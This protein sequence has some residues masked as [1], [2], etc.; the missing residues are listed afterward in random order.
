MSTFI[1]VKQGQPA[2]SQGANGEIQLRVI[3]GRYFLFAKVN[4]IW[5]SIELV[6]GGLALA[7][8]AG[9]IGGGAVAS[10]T[11]TIDNLTVKNL[12]VDE[13]FI[14]ATGTSRP[15]FNVI[16]HVVDD[17]QAHEDYIRNIG[18]DKMSGSLEITGHDGA[19]YNQDFLLRLFDSQTNYNAVYVKNPQGGANMQVGVN[20]TSVMTGTL[21][22]G[23]SG[24]D[25]IVHHNG[26]VQIGQV[27]VEGDS[28]N[29]D[30]NAGSLTCS[31]I[32]A[33]DIDTGHGA[34][35]VYPLNNLYITTAGFNES[36]YLTWAN[37][38]DTAGNV[39]VQ[40]P[41]DMNLK[42]VNDSI[43]D[44]KLAYNTGQH[45]TTTSNVIH[46]NLYLNDAHSSS[47]PPLHVNTAGYTKILLEDKANNE[48]LVKINTGN[49]GDLNFETPNFKKVTVED[50]T[51]FGSANFASGFTGAGWQVERDPL[52]NEY[53]ATFDELTVRG[54]LSVYELLIQQI[55]ATNG[56][57]II[58]SG[59]RVKEATR[60][61]PEN[62][63]GLNYT[64]TVED[65]SEP[66]SN[67]Y[68]MANAGP[69][70]AWDDGRFFIFGGGGGVDSW[71][72][73]VIN[74]IAHNIDNDGNNLWNEIYSTMVEGDMFQIYENANNYGWF[75]CYTAPTIHGTL[76][77]NSQLNARQVDGAFLGTGPNY[78]GGATHTFKFGGKAATVGHHVREGDLLLAQKWT[79]IGEQD[80]PFQPIIQ[81]KIIVSHIA[82]SDAN[83]APNQFRANVFSTQEQANTM[84]QNLPLDF[85]RVGNET[86]INRQGGIYLTSEDDGAPFIDIYDQVTSWNDWRDIAKTKARLGKLSGITYDSYDIGNTYGLFSSDVFLTGNITAKGGYIGN[87]DSGWRIDAYGIRNANSNAESRITIGDGYHASANTGFYVGGDGNFSL[88]DKL[89]WN[90]ASNT[91]AVV[92]EAV[93]GL[94]QGQYPLEG[95]SNHW[96]M[97]MGDFIERGTELGWTCYED[98]SNLHPNS[99]SSRSNLSVQDL[100]MSSTDQGTGF[101][102]SI[103][104]DSTGSGD[105]GVEWSTE[106]SFGGYYL[107]F[108]NDG[109]SK[110]SASWM[111]QS[112]NSTNASGQMGTSQP[113]FKHSWSM[114]YRPRGANLGS[115]YWD[116]ISRW[117]QN[118]DS[119]WPRLQ[120]KNWH[121]GGTP[122]IRYWIN[123]GDEFEDI[124]CEMDT[125]CLLV[126]SV[127][128]DDTAGGADKIELWNYS[129]A[130]GLIDYRINESFSWD[131]FPFSETDGK[132]IWFNP[133]GGLKIDVSEIRHWN[134][135]H[136]S[137]TD[138]AQIWA[139]PNGPSVTKV[140]GDSIVTGQ[141]LSQNFSVDN[142]SRIDLKTGAMAMGGFSCATSNHLRFDP[143]SGSISIKCD[144]ADLTGTFTF[145][146][147]ENVQDE[148]N[149]A[150][151]DAANASSDAANASSDAANAS[152]DASNASSEA[153]N[154]QATAEQAASDASNAQA[155]AD[156]ANSDAANAST[157][158]ADAASD[159]AQAAANAAANDVLLDAMSS[160]SQI[161]P[162]E[163]L[164]GWP[165]YQTVLI[166]REEILLDADD[167]DLP[168]SDYYSSYNTLYTYVNTTTSTYSNMATTTN[169]VRA[170]WD[171]AWDSYY[172]ERTKLQSNIVQA[173]QAVANTANTYAQGYASDAANAAEAA[174]NAEAQAQAAFSNAYTDTANTY[175]TDYT[176]TS[177]TTNWDLTQ[178]YTNTSNTYNS[179]YTD[180][181]NTYN[182][183]Y[184]DTSNTENWNS[185]QDYT[186]TSNTYNSDYTDTTNTTNWNATQDYTNAANTYTQTY[187]GWQADGANTNT[188]V[189]AAYADY[190]N[191][192]ADTI[193]AYSQAI[194]A[195]ISTTATNAFD[196][197]VSAW[198]FAN[199]SA[200]GANAYADTQAAGANS[201][202][203]SYSSGVGTGAN[204]VACSYSSGVGA[205]ANNYSDSS[206]A[207]AATAANTYACAHATIAGA[208]S[209]AANAYIFS[210]G[211]TTINGGNITTGTISA[212]AV[213]ATFISAQAAA[214]NTLIAN[215]IAA[216]NIYGSYIAATQGTVG[217]FHLNSTTLQSADGKLKLV[218]TSGGAY[219]EVTV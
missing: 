181:S 97:H 162:V 141:L 159:A 8:A 70:F 151:S 73:N 37:A 196:N 218:S 200:I 197:V 123:A 144:N 107:K 48:S 41:Y 111:I 128:V 64:F 191:A 30:T 194:S 131:G 148:V 184:T 212:D 40:M 127:T 108:D 2:Q 149:T 208:M 112:A 22:I 119:Y 25:F 156:Q 67:S 24:N 219:I 43:D 110:R 187:A 18:Y 36:A 165:I 164:T 216:S 47:E 193:N 100:H 211:V 205:G 179:N 27:F 138:V 176:D 185:T 139:M 161:T 77:N 60:N 101:E 95:M 15:S 129:T 133:Q 192:Y 215:E 38:T 74:V 20:T 88:G 104:I 68:N 55:K 66:T 114:Y 3:S 166:E 75:K 188:V 175:N 28:G 182:E 1:E 163:K 202:A 14:D 26:S 12:K 137:N 213:D 46:S 153:S 89:T 91:L 71:Q 39:R 85:V 51:G 50:N 106:D 16:N 35:E 154:A 84:L 118:N 155:T 204:S 92:G 189:A 145:G 172:N 209:T 198:S 207:A 61:D 69:S 99:F 113:V 201:V 126:W 45:L 32:T 63:W 135:R 116:I 150:A 96:P 79:G 117:N 87:E 7:Q 33:W 132:N 180:T 195:G 160:D 42:L 206:A 217:G 56:S 9:G 62:Y 81:S 80:P 186:N 72:A 94:E 214:I 171:S 54:T 65:D 52:S 183:T 13:N 102:G 167:Y 86:D 53:E 177:N 59:D 125:W 142:G 76:A 120:A 190:A 158:A 152:S 147:G 122:K 170:T 203:C 124:A 23:T 82:N 174:A 109:G 199:S 58:G 29:V 21:H 83:L 103:Y 173:A 19:Q 210:S 178:D 31:H 10:L 57:L 115:N 6:A 44:Y 93:I 169:I 146:S 5:K 157:A 49:D 134:N 4:G 136:L 90:A 98:T 121:T 17:T 140:D 78:S 130:N 143:G 34:N 11:G 168:S 105:P